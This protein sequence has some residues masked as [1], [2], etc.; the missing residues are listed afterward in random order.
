MSLDIKKIRADYE[1]LS[2][3]VGGQLPIYFDNACTTLRPASV[4]KAS[5]TYYTD[6]PACHNRAV[7]K[8][9][10][11]TT[12]EYEAARSTVARF[13]GADK[14]QEIVFTR[15]TTEGI[16]LIANGLD[17]KKGDI[18]LT[19]NMEHNSNLIPWQMLAMEKG[20][21]HKLV[22]IKKDDQ[23]FDLES[24]KKI[25]TEGKVRLV[26]VFHTSN[27]TGM[28]LPIKEM[29]QIAH[30]NGAFFLLDAAQ[31]IAHQ[32]INVKEL[33]V[34][35]LAF[36]FHKAFGPSGFGSLYGKFELLQKLKPLLYGGETVLDAD[37]TS[38]TFAE[39]PYRL[40]AGLQNYAGAIGGAEA[41][42][43]IEKL[44]IESFH[45]HEVKINQFITQE[46]L[47]HSSIEILGPKEAELR[48]GILNFSVKN[49]DMGELSILLDESKNIMTR[50][51]FHCAHAWFHKENLPPTLR[52][53]FSVYNTQ[54]EA[55]TFVSVINQIIQFY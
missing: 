36:S 10:K 4:I 3:K 6:H 28:S 26:S 11:Q 1:V 42:R 8:F 21:V 31:A 5:Q 52:L 38:F 41:L 33:D 23:A 55:E 50:S 34:D 39:T 54:E 19:T 17:F 46:L 14:P 48:S 24:Y 29:V 43:Y 51:G 47:K 44:G 13:L 22:D 53:S 37:Y 18:V 12:K 16:N 7:H 49:K 27:V 35:F 25:F 2:K 15:N 30:E 20:I 40:E 45:Q 9:G 32:K